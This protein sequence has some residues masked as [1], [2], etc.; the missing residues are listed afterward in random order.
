MIFGNIIFIEKNNIINLDIYYDICSHPLFRNKIIKRYK[1]T[2]FIDYIEG[3]EN[4]HF[5]QGITVGGLLL[6][7]ENKIEFYHNIVILDKTTI[8]DQG[9]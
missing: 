5:S 7:E 6:Q 3:D 8:K 2:N 9:R 4:K 1:D